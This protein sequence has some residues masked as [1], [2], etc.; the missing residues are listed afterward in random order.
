MTVLITVIVSIDSKMLQVC[1][2][3]WRSGKMNEQFDVILVSDCVLPKLYPIAPLVELRKSDAV[4]IH[5][6]I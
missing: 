6:V 4:A 2:Y 1:E 5:P 3:W